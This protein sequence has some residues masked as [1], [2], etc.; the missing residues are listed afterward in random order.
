MYAKFV[1][2]LKSQKADVGVYSSIEPLPSAMHSGASVVLQ[3]TGVRHE[4]AASSTPNHSMPVLSLRACP[5]SQKPV[6]CVA[7]ARS[8]TYSLPSTSNDMGRQ[9]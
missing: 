9:R 4:V 3:Y 7:V 2:R 6:C 5:T 1:T 8:F